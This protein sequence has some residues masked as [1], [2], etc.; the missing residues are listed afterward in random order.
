MGEGPLERRHYAA[1]VPDGPG[2]TR[3]KIH[4]M[5][6]QLVQRWHG[7]VEGKLQRAT[8]QSVRFDP[9]LV[10]L[11]HRKGRRLLSGLRVR[12]PGTP[13]PFLPKL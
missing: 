8:E 6:R 10:N 7:M 13:P 4:V 5:M 9:A 12:R 11:G 2:A 3:C 1:G